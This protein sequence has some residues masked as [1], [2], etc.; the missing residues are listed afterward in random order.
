M[1]LCGVQT[2]RITERDTK[3]AHTR[4]GGVQAKVK[5]ERWADWHN[6]RFSRNGHVNRVLLK[7]ILAE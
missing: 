6:W 1:V 5:I 4:N 2:I 7:G 3:V